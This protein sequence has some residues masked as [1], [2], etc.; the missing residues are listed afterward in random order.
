MN[1]F[2]ETKTYL[3]KYLLGYKERRVEEKVKEE[4]KPV[5]YQLLK[6][7]SHSIIRFG[8]NELVA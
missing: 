2:L 1:K 4:I 8:E 7:L 5:F 6:F 3:C